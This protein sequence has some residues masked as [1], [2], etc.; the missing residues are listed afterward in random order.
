VTLREFVRIVLEFARQ[1][2]LSCVFPFSFVAA[3]ALTKRV[4]L[5][6]IPRYDLLLLIGLTIQAL[7]LATRMETRDELK[8]ICVFHV[9]GLAL[10][11]F[12]VRAGSWAYPESAWT[13]VGGVPLYS[14]FMYASV[15]SYMCQAWRRLD[16]RLER[17]PPS[18]AVSLLAAALYL[19]FFTH[20][21]LPDFRWVLAACVL[22]VFARTRVGYCVAG[23]GLR[24]PMPV[25]FLL[26]G[27]FVWIAENIATRL[28]A[29]Q[30]PHQ[31]SGWQM[32]HA[33]KIGSWTL[34]S[35]VSL[36]VVAQLKRVKYGNAGEERAARARIR[37]QKTSSKHGRK[38]L[39]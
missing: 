10:E 33:E 13:K 1:Q 39:G 31:A 24:M 9:L 6:G 34:L 22:V 25:A 11:L 27:L 18:F 14:G 12:K 29:W 19:N 17:W 20:H 16:L 5:P 28:G 4:G 23:H 2:A 37:L 35:I 30:Y 15:A 8:V 38:E 26:I 36:V 21:Y 7:M 3:L 32:V